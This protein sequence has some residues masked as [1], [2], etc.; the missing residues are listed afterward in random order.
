LVRRGGC[1][2]EVGNFADVG[3]ITISPST[4]CRND[5]S[6]IGSVLGSP[7][8]YEHAESI[9]NKIKFDSHDFLGPTY[10]LDEVSL[11]IENVS[12][13]KNGLKTLIATNG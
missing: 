2:I 7:D 1:I 11:A 6:I 9:V 5:I 8:L 12:K 3:S 13:I 10:S 4:I